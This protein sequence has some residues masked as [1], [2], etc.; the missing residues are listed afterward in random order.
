MR[1]SRSSV[2]VTAPRGVV[3]T[4]LTNPEFVRQ[5][6]YGSELE[7][8]WRVGESIRFRGQWQG[9]IF[10]QWGTVQEF[11][12]PN[13]LRYS[14][15]APRPGLEDRPENYFT[16][17]YEVSEGSDGTTVMFVHEDPRSNADDDGDAVDATDDENPV[18]IALKSIAESL[19][20]Q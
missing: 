17:T 8:T 5:W 11:D 9:E 2:I 12:V 14:L 15:F 10:E 1:V 20:L 6:Q 16:M 3:W 4:V 13:R 18:L 7:T 19:A